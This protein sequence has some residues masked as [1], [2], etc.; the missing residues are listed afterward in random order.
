VLFASAPDTAG[1]AI[2][3]R[4]RPAVSASV[5]AATARHE[6]REIG[7]RMRP[8]RGARGARAARRVG[9]PTPPRRTL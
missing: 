1:S 5:T 8:V 2:C 4:A 3:A 6:T 7:A 9:A